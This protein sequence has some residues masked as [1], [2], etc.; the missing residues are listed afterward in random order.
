MNEVDVIA[1]RNKLGAIVARYHELLAQDEPSM[2]HRH[3]IGT[4][5]ALQAAFGDMNEADRLLRI[6]IVGR[7]KA[8]KS[9]L[10]NGLLFDGQSVLPKAAT[11]MTAALTMLAYGQQFAAEVEFFSFDDIAAMRASHAEFERLLQADLEARLVASSGAEQDA[12]SAARAQRQAM[13][14]LRSRYASLSAAHEQFATIKLSGILLSELGERK[15][16]TAQSAADLNASLRDY[17]GAG[18]RYTPFT[19]N[20]RMALPH[21]CLRDIEI[22]DTPGLND[23]V[24]SREERTCEELKRCDVILIVSPAGQFLTAE[25]LELMGRIVQKDGV[26]ELRVLASQVDTQ[27]F[28]GEY[29]GMTLPAVLDNIT[30][31]LGKRMVETLTQIRTGPAGMGTTFDALIAQ[32]RGKVHHSSG[33]CHALQA[34]YG[35]PELWDEGQRKVWENLQFAYPDNFPDGDAALARANLDLLAN[36]DAVQQTIDDVRQQKERIR[37]ERKKAFGQDQARNLALYRGEILK[38]AEEEQRQLRATNISELERLKEELS[39]DAARLDVALNEEMRSLSHALRTK[40]NDE[41]THAIERQFT[42]TQESKGEATTTEDRQ[43]DSD[44][45]GVIPAVFRFLGVG[46]TSR[47]YFVV[48]KVNTGQVESAMMDFSDKVLAQL[49]SLAENARSEW[50]VK[51]RKD[52]LSVLRQV[53]GDKHVDDI[54]ARRTIMALVDSIE[55]PTPDIDLSLPASLAPRGTL[56]G[57]QADTYLDDANS[58]ITTLKRRFSA[59]VRDYLTDVKARLDADVVAGFV[60]GYTGRINK[61]EAQIGAKHQVTLRLQALIRELNE[62]A[63]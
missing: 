25:D 8:G 36:M 16:L 6:G 18:G 13:R 26:R 17:V 30:A 56:T 48:N 27:L 43:R 46:G 39:H 53:I 59:S 44:K 20:V 10:L 3:G 49:A 4:S 29:R 12:A 61:L 33:A 2:A 62:V 47:T 1:L 45:S 54:L 24:I 9:S 22:I 34:Q 21:D 40:L 38:F 42:L 14:E 15:T 58:Y 7:V 31:S 55:L 60:E 11:P 32:G 50:E 51:V 23:P 37:D 19:R 35:E 57:E 28:G 52:L 5:Q 63:L 41:L